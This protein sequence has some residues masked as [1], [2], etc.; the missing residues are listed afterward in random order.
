MASRRATSGLPARPSELGHGERFGRLGRRLGSSSTAAKRRSQTGGDMAWGLQRRCEQPRRAAAPISQ[1][2]VLAGGWG[3]PHD[4]DTAGGRLDGR[5]VAVDPGE[6][7]GRETRARAY[8]YAAGAGRSAEVKGCRSSSPAVG[9]NGDLGHDTFP[10]RG[11]STRGVGL[12]HGPSVRRP[13]GPLRG[14]ARVSGA[15]ESRSSWECRWLPSVT[16]LPTAR[17]PRHPNPQRGAERSTA[18]SIAPSWVGA[19]PGFA[20][21]RRQGDEVAGVRLDRSPP[22]PMTRRGGG[23]RGFLTHVEGTPL[24]LFSSTVLFSS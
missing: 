21:R 9:W 11:R 19:K 5:H 17:A 6:R 4:V 16:G 10:H 24:E 20:A 23:E 14:G 12:L 13:L 8:G 7:L 22:A 2:D 15:Q 1:G 3:S 18:L